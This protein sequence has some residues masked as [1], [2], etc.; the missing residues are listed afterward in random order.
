[1]LSTSRGAQKKKC[2]TRRKSEKPSAQVADAETRYRGGKR[3]KEKRVLS[4]IQLHTTQA[5]TSRSVE[6]AAVRRRVEGRNG[7]K[8]RGKTLF[9]SFQSRME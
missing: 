2:V 4:L 7:E 6:Y 1:M 5:M 9:L 3:K 8:Q